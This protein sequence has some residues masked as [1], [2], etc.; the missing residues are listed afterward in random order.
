MIRRVL[1]M[2]AGGLM[3]AGASQAPEFAQQYSQ[4][5]GGAVDELRTIVQS[6]D[7]DARRNG[8]SRENGLMRLETAQDSFT[9]ARGEAQRRTIRRFEQ[10]EAQK[11]AMD[12]PD[13]TTR[14]AAMVR[15]YDA[16]VGRRAM[17]DFRPAAPLTLE[18]LFFGLI[19]FAAGASA[20][21]IA[22]LPM[23][24]RKPKPAPASIRRTAP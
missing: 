1:S 22:A 20:M 9:A 19:G 16:D 10:L 21:G 23:G 24:R 15:N 17:G 12:A 7:A 14:V 4:R 3:A 5:L 18:G 11:A 2:F 13:V 6:F 8:L